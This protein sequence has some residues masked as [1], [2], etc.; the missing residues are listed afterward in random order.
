M[1]HCPW[2]D[3]W[4]YSTMWRKAGAGPLNLRR[5]SE[6]RLWWCLIN[7]LCYR[8]SSFRLFSNIEELF[9]LI[10]TVYSQSLEHRQDAINSVS[11]T[12]TP[13]YGASSAPAF[14][15]LLRLNVLSRPFFLFLPT[16]CAW[17]LLFIIFRSLIIISVQAFPFNTFLLHCLQ[18]RKRFYIYDFFGKA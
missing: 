13:E 14:P 1:T 16:Q 3:W 17:Q 11:K 12:L 18:W 10:Y 8:R 2:A 5:T 15:L 9:L 4:N 6:S 7:H